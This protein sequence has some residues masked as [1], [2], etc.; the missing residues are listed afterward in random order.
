MHQTRLSVEEITCV[1][2]EAVPEMKK[3]RVIILTNAQKL[4][5]EKNTTCCGILS[6]LLIKPGSLQ[7]TLDGHIVYFHGGPMCCDVGPGWLQ[8]E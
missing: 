8:Q 4:R 3:K 2:P 6:Q 1:F 5:K 7:H